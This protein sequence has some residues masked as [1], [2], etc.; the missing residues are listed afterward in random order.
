MRPTESDATGCATT[1][2]RLAFIV[3]HPI[4]Y[5]VPLYRSLARREDLLIKV[6]FTWHSGGPN[7]R[8]HGFKRAVAWDIPLTEGYEFELVPNV[9]RKTGTHCFWGLRNPSLISSVTSW[10]PDVV[11][12]TGYAHFSHVR[13]MRHFHRAGI[14]VLFRGDSHLLRTSYGIRWRIKLALLR[15]VYGWTDG[16]LYVGQH[17]AD[18]FRKFGVPESRL[19]YCP[20]SI[21][22]ERFAEP[23]D[24]LEKE[25]DGWRRELQIGNDRVVVLFAGKFE[26]VKQPLALMR[27]FQGCAAEDPRLLLVMVG[28]GELGHEVRRTAVQVPETFRVLPFQNQT[29]MP[30]VYRVGHLFV[31]PSIRESWGLSVNEAMACG[32]PALVSDGVGCGDDL[33]RANETGAIFPRNDWDAFC[34]T[35][36]R[37]TRDRLRL[38]QMGIAARRLSTTFD[39]TATEGA[40][41]SALHRVLPR[42]PVCR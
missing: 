42:I 19:F 22:V 14:P 32:R 3:S 29:R 31:L 36:I 25:A 34:K 10:K 28:D 39:I 41:L 38:E 8:D 11:H 13:A 40:L 27:A 23:N 6:F 26:R 9:A 37:L 12:L 20:H 30:L 4:Q 16:C 2:I 21:E 33:V 1:P 18:Y 15:R 7:A 35:L 5:Y 17:N 24:T